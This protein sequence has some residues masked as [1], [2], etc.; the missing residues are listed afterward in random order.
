MVTS[1]QNLI[2]QNSRLMATGGGGRRPTSTSNF[3][4]TGERFLNNIS[5]ETTQNAKLAYYE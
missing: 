2:V 5:L 3:S 1:M 4:G